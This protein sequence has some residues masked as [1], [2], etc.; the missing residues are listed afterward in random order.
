METQTIL[1]M[2]RQY[3]IEVTILPKLINIFKQFQ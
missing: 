2:A 3:I 1:Q